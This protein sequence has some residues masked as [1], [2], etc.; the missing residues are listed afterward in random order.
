MIIELLNK[1]RHIAILVIHHLWHCFIKIID[2]YTSPYLLSWWTSDRCSVDN[3]QH[4]SATRCH[5]IQDIWCFDH[6]RLRLL[7]TNFQN[8]LMSYFWPNF[9]CFYYK[10]FHLPVHVKL[11]YLV[12]LENKN[13]VDFNS[14]HCKLLSCLSLRH[15]IGKY[16]TSIN[17]LYFL[18]LHF[19]FITLLFTLLFKQ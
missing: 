2:F 14:I 4:V 1:K 5:K 9:V 18:T 8:V 15:F 16:N 19:Y 12:K 7:S 17:V 6:M 11:H 3:S 10:N 13:A